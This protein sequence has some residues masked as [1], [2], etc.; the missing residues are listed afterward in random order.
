MLAVGLLFGLTV[1]G[2]TGHWLANRWIDHRWYCGHRHRASHPCQ[3][4]QENLERW[5]RTEE[6]LNRA[7]DLDHEA[8]R[9]RRYF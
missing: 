6:R 3:P 1:G 5:S 7:E 8:K 9:L 4:T 2:F